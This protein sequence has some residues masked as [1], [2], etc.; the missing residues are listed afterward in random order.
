MLPQ[1]VAHFRPTA[2]I[3]RKNAAAAQN[4]NGKSV[5]NRFSCEVTFQLRFRGA[6]ITSGF[7]LNLSAMIQAAPTF[8][9]FRTKRFFPPPRLALWRTRG[10]RKQMSCDLDP[11]PI[12]RT[13]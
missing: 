1:V 9:A 13:A 12:P 6:S 7:I 3:V 2:L 10:A 5:L 4:S 8:A 11:V